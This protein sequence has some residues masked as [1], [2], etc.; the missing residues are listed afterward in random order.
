M[1]IFAFL[2]K[3]ENT[4]HSGRRGTFYAATRSRPQR[5]G[6]EGHGATIC[7]MA[8]PPMPMTLL[9]GDLGY[10]VSLRRW[11]RLDTPGRFF[12]VHPVSTSPSPAPAHPRRGTSGL[13]GREEE[14]VFLLEERWSPPSR[15][16]EPWCPRP[17]C[18]HGDKAAL[19]AALASKQG[20]WTPPETHTLTQQGTGV[21]LG[22]LRDAA[23]KN[24]RR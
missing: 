24:R 8:H 5:S 1:R 17:E 15:R 9:L 18:V 11:S 22:L 3:L 10:V 23:S 16:G 7:H 4:G 13:F 21:S 2:P 6:E 19:P 20:A 14:A 12:S